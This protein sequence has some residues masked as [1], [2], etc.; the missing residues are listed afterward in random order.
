LL[1]KLTGVSLPWQNVPLKQNL[2]RFFS[3]GVAIGNE[4]DETKRELRSA[5]DSLN[6]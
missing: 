3:N 6:K 4:D 1:L 5:L 2:I